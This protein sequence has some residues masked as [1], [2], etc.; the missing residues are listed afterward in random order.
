VF[1]LDRLRK[2]LNNSLLEQNNDK[3][4]EVKY[5][6]DVEYKVEEILAV[7]KQG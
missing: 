5:N 2:D 4:V 6:R 3:P 1:S 7:R